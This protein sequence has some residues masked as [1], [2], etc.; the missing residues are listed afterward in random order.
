MAGRR[1]QQE[2]RQFNT[3]WEHEY[4]FISPYHN[5]K[6]HCVIC[7]ESLSVMKRNN[8]RRHF[9]AKHLQFNDKYPLGTLKRQMKLQQLKSLF[10]LELD[11]TQHQSARQEPTYETCFSK[12][13]TQYI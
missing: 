7:L 12:P 2:N 5:A 10:F 13:T 8:V 6:P 11:S 3:E 9:E 1:I 4:F